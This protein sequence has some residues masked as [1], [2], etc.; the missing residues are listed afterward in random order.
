MIHYVIR[1]GILVGD[2]AFFGARLT[3][4]TFEGNGVRIGTYA[5]V[6]DDQRRQGF[7]NSNNNLAEVYSR[8][9][10][11]LYRRNANNYLSPW[12]KQ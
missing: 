10:A 11:G 7:N 8:G 9:G 5:F 1:D 6:T 2:N 3:N 12:A 4:I